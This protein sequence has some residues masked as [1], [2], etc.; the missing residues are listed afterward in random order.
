MYA[1]VCLY[2]VLYKRGELS[3]GDGRC[4]VWVVVVIDGDYGVALGC[5]DLLY[6][7][8]NPGFDDVVVKL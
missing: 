3:Y 5:A 7:M 6:E 8:V 4:G 1:Y 2:S